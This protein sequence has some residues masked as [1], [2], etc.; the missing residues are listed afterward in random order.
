[1]VTLIVFKISKVMSSSP[2]ILGHP[3]MEQECTKSQTDS[4]APSPPTLR[5]REAEPCLV[6]VTRRYQGLPGGGSGKASTC[7]CRK[8]R[9]GV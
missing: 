4:T 8:R 5:D 2:Q 6:N 3:G 9:D 1:M 7:Q